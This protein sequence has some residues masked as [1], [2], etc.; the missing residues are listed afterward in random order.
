MERTLLFQRRHNNKAAG[1][2]NAHV[3]EFIIINAANLPLG[4]SIGT[5]DLNVLLAKQWLGV[6][7]Q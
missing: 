4:G 7:W 3:G 5:V 2:K 1:G 6:K